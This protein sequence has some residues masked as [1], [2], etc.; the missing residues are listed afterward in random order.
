MRILFIGDIIGKAGRKALLTLLEGLVETEGI[1]FT[2]A[3]G[4][5]RLEELGSPLKLQ[6]RFWKRG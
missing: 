1:D 5:M 3:N 4:E 2:I 6:L